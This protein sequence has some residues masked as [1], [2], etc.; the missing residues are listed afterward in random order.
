[1]PIYKV[2]DFLS[3]ISAFFKNSDAH[4]AMY[5]ILD[6]IKWLKMSEKPLLG[7]KSRC[8]NV[9]SLL[10]VFQT[11]LLFPCFMVRNPYNYAGSSLSHLMDCKKDVFYRFMN[12]PCIDWRKL[13]YHLN[14][15][16]WSKI[17]VR[18]EH[19]SNNTCLIVDDTDYPKSGRCIENMGRVYSH[20][21]NRCILG[22]KAL[23]LAITDG[24]SQ[25]L[26]D[27]AILGEKGKNGNFGM[28]ANEL[29]RRFTKERNE[30]KPFK[31]RIREYSRKKTELMIEMIRRAIKRGIKFRYVLAD[32]WF[33]NKDII[34][35]IH[36]RHIKCDYLGMI[37]VGT[38]GKTTYHFERKDFTAPAL[39][40]L[41]VKRGQ[42]KYSRKLRCHYMTADATFGGVPV[43]LFFVKRNKKGDW[44]ALITT[45]TAL[46][47]FEAYR[48]YSQRWALEVVFKESKCLLGLGKCQANN[49]A[50]QIAATS[51]TA[52][53]YNILSVVKRFAAYE[54]MGKLF[55][56]VSKD[57]LEL[58]VTERIWGALQE[59]VIA[60]ANLFGLTDEDIYDAIINRSEEIKHV[61]DIYK[62]KL[63][64]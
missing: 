29:K 38:K 27:F 4:N 37:K 43:R 62:L 40:K 39:I 44:N 17:R 53:Q 45:D 21:Q 34:R 55:E 5:S 10:Q 52:L 61:F 46:D 6:V 3:E 20:V 33:A 47:F 54:T 18:S 31:E 7:I 51:L 50:S 28:S 64:S 12:N 8:N 42:K 48:L 49:F 15:Q 63:A 19:K 22:F 1:M 41:L 26:L 56:D 13:L 60:I 24:K 9:Y 35:F 58:S 14:L 16:L 36:S 59:V 11:L 30:E 57:S 2:T 32:S 23:F 25:L